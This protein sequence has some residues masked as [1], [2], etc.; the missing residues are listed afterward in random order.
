MIFSA[1][2]ADTS[3]SRALRRRTP[4]AAEIDG[5]H[6]ARTA[7]CAPFTRGVLPRPQLGREALLACWRDEAS[8]DRFLEA[9]PT[10]QAFNAGWHVRMELIRAAGVWPGTDE[11]MSAEAGTRVRTATGPTVAVTIGTAYLKTAIA[12]TRVNNGLEDQFLDTPS[13]IW[14]TLMT[15]LP[16][17]LVATLTIWKSAEAAFDYVRTG[18]HG[19]AVTAHYDPD[20][21]PT[22]HTFV[23]G[24][25]FFGFTPLSVHGSVGGKNP[26]A[27]DLLH[28]PPP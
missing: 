8:L 9:H 15:N 16:Q 1:H 6:S 13:G 11:D 25:G 4:Q 2:V 3:A 5:L 18:A 27:A 24:G 22:G 23:T 10:G 19:A 17:R 28:G 26:I 12:F 20:K 21:D 7:V 14:G